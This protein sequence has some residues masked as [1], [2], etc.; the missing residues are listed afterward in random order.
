MINRRLL[1]GSVAMLAA[2]PFSRDS[3]AAEKFTIGYSVFWGTNP[4]LVTMV[5]GAKKAAEE[6]GAK[7]YEVDLVVT[8]GGDDDKTKQVNDLQDLYAQGVKGVL[9]FPGD[10][11][12]VTEP[13][14]STYNKNNVPVVITDIGVRGGDIASFIIT[15]NYAGGGLAAERLAKILK[16]GAKVVTFD[17]APT[18]DNAQTRKKG[19]EETAKKLGLT[20]LPTLG[21]PKGMTL[22]SGRQAMEDTLVAEP[23][24]AGAFSFNQVIMQGASAALASA[25]RADV[26]L[27]AFDLDPVSYKMVADGKIDSLVVQDPY[28][29]GYVGLNQ[30]MNKLTGGK[31]EAKIGL[32]T[33]LLTKDNIA[34]FANDP[35]VTG[36]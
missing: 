4:F 15:D 24:I 36:K 8:N 11:I 12:L 5:R 34:E 22:D 17:Y 20:V 28:Q 25:N 3:W 18:N 27:T 16:P 23:D 31:V 26:K 1:L 30:M 10:S 33:K 14:I 35:Q 32:G 19:F 6:W 13:I 7:G 9:I 2:T 29:M 21:L